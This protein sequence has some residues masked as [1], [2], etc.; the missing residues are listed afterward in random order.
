MTWNAQRKAVVDQKGSIM[1]FELTC[2]ACPEQYDVYHTFSTPAGPIEQQV[3]YVRL[4]YGK[5]RAYYPD[6]GGELIYEYIFEDEKYLGIFPDELSRAHHL[7]KIEEAI[8]ARL[9]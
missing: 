8:Y 1:L 3:A 9:S 5:L 2:Q 7:T 6:V 4:R